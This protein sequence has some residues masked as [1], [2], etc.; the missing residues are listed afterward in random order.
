MRDQELAAPAE[1]HSCET[2]PT[3]LLLSIFVDGIVG[4]PFQS[5]RRGWYL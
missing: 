2:D 4:P 3:F 1:M 5:C